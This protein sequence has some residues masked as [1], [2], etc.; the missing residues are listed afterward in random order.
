MRSRQRSEPHMTVRLEA[1]ER[2]QPV[3]VCAGQMFMSLHL[4]PSNAAFFHSWT[5]SSLSQD[6]GESE[7]RSAKC[8]LDIAGIVKIGAQSAA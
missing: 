1:Q 8:A 6:E 7:N 2:R 5:A 4:P 3:S